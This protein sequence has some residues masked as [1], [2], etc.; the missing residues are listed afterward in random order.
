MEADRGAPDVPQPLHCCRAPTD[1][2]QAA[3]LGAM[4]QIAVGPA[5]RGALAPR[6]NVARLGRIKPKRC[7]VRLVRASGAA[8]AEGGER[9]PEPPSSR[10]AILKGTL[11]LLAASG[12]LGSAQVRGAGLHG[13]RL[14]PP[15]PLLPV[16]ASAQLV[17]LPSIILPHH[18]EPITNS[19]PPLQAAAAVDL[20]AAAEG[21]VAAAGDASA[22]TGLALPALGGAVV[23]AAA[24][25][26]ALSGGSKAAEERAAEALAAAKAEADEAS[27][28]AQRRLEGVR[29]EVQALQGKQR[30]LEASASRKA[31][32]RLVGC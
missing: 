23:G 4:A 17:A 9:T 22:A 5:S 10:R 11:Q 12:M 14:P 25:A 31:Q 15:P 29:S 1:I 32:V 20:A 8:G 16:Q 2:A 13:R 18:H 19:S 6:R 28:E 30:E 7:T 24:A 27:R 21:A 26:A 3:E